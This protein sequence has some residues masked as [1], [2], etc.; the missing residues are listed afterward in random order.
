[1]SR[2]YPVGAASPTITIVKM[3]IFIC[4]SKAFYGKISS[5]K[6]ELEKKGHIITL[7]NS[8][9]NPGREDEQRA[10]GASTHAAWKAKMIRLQEKKV[11]ANDAIL[12]LNFTKNG[13]QN[14]IG[15]ATFLEMFKAFELGKKIYL[16][17]PI[18]A[19]MLYDEIHSFEPVVI[20]G[21]LSR[22]T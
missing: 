20:N 15:G 16:Y 1:M 10:Q 3:K 19:G 21:D 5:I 12:V 22:V 9:D 7:P 8:Y 4:A 17:N 13:Q 18:P 11:K 2:N 6:P 14:Y